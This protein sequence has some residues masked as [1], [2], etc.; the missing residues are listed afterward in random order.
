MLC[1]NLMC[2]SQLLCLKA[3]AEA[4]GGHGQ[5]TFTPASLAA[6][7][8]E[9]RAA[10]ASVREWLPPQFHDLLEVGAHRVVS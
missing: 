6:A 5:P 2:R 3:V 4:M 7:L 10:A 8:S 9:S 1:F